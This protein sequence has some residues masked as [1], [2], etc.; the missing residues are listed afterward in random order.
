MGVPLSNPG[1]LS[2]G[3]LELRR[4]KVLWFSGLDRRLLAV[5]FRMNTGEALV[6]EEEVMVVAACPLLQ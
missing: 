1:S 3:M 2:D 4:P 6:P 5:C